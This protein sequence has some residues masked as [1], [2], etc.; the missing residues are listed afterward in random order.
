MNN[1]GKQM[2]ESAKVLII[3]TAK[4]MGL[5]EETIQRLVEPERSV[6]VNFP[7]VMDDKK[8]RIFTGFR[9]QHNSA[10]GPYKGGIR[11]HKDTV[12]EE[13]QALATLMSI[14]CAVAGLPYG[15]GK[16]GVIVDPHT[17]SVHELERV[18]RAYAAHIA[19]VIGPDVDV[20]APDVNTNAQIMAWMLDEYEKIVGHKSPS[21]FTG[22]P[23]EKGGSLGRTEATGRGGVIVLKALLKLMLNEVKRSEKSSVSAKQINDASLD[24]S[25]RENLGTQHDYNTIA[26]QGFGNV[27]FYFAKLAQAEGFTVVAVSDS[28]GGVY[29]PE[30]LDPDA[31]IECKREKGSVAGCYCKGSVCDVKYGKP[32]SNEELLELPVDILV[33]SAL[34]NVINKDNMKKI[35][36]KIIVEMAN[37]PVTEEA[38]EYLSQKGVVIV[39]DVLANSG[40]VTVSYLEWVQGKQGYWWTESE[41]NA[42]LEEVMKRA[43]DAVWERA[44]KEK[45][46]LKQAAFEVALQ[47]IVKA[48][49]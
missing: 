30:G 40:G 37:G 49:G 32:L 42:K 25:S 41:V 5:P 2:L 24:V 1:P 46:P 23:I 38:Y 10:L 16:G 12:K 21:A 35:Q 39:P 17:L 6:E 13:V 28:K 11:F 34:E 3:K 15:G 44:H 47:K 4:S 20:P 31:T 14:K 36:A 7:V 8:E 9:I 18:A 43:T 33:P 29:V 26:V 19:T 22:K 27:G 48:M 45:I